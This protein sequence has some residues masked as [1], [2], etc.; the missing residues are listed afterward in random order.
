MTLKI[1]FE[2]PETDC[3]VLKVPS[4]T[5]SNSLREPLK[6]GNISPVY[7]KEQRTAFLKLSLENL[8]S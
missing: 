1:V 8:K 5:M 7:I 4:D 3:K 2:A 6:F